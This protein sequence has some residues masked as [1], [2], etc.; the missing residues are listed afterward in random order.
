MKAGFPADAVQAFHA[1]LQRCLVGLLLPADA[2]S[3]GVG[4]VRAGGAAGGGQR[5]HA[6][7]RRSVRGRHPRAHALHRPAHRR[8]VA[9]RRP[10]RLPAPASSSYQLCLALAGIYE[11]VFF[12]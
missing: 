11:H 9:A 5:A 8:P 12:F 1:S 4:G 6:G 7:A 3:A 2:A 10:F